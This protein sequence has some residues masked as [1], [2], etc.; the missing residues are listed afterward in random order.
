MPISYQRQR[1]LST[2]EFSSQLTLTCLVDDLR[3]CRS[4]EP[5]PEECTATTLKDQ[6]TDISVGAH[7]TAWTTKDI[8]S[9]PIFALYIGTS[10]LTT[11]LIALIIQ[12][13][14][15]KW[16]GPLSFRLNLHMWVHNQNLTLPMLTLQDIWFDT[17]SASSMKAWQQP[18]HL[19]KI[20]NPFHVHHLKGC[21]RKNSVKRR[22][23]TQ[24]GTRYS[25]RW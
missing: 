9:I 13:D 5:M 16:N 12:L 2:Y 19:I 21:T 15:P 3:L 18:L 22:G 1:N 6:T 17:E 7:R 14:L 11:A 24:F 4:L 20:Q 23:L 10:G 8:S 25:F